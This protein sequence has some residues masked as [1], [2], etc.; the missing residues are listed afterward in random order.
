MSELEDAPAPSCRDATSP[1]NEAAREQ[2]NSAAPS[3][4]GQ[5]STMGHDTTPPNTSVALTKED[6]L[7]A[8]LAFLSAADANTLN[9][10]AIG[11]AAITYFVLGRLGILLMGA[12][13]GAVLVITWEKNHPETSRSL[14]GEKGADILERFLR[15]HKDATTSASGALRLPED[16]QVEGGKFSGFENFQPETG[17]ALDDVVDAVLRDYVKWWYTP[18]VPTDKSFP[19]SCRKTLTSF[20]VSVSKHLSRKRPADSFLD[21]LAN[22]SYLVVVFFSE[23]ACAFAEV[24]PESDMTVVDVIYNYLASNPECNL[25]NLVSRKQQESKFCMISED[26]LQFLDRPTY[27]CGLVRVFLREILAGVILETTLQKCSKP[28][29]INGWIVHLLE[30]GETDFNQALDA[31]MQT[32]PDF[33]PLGGDVGNMAIPK[34]TRKPFEQ[35]GLHP[36]RDSENLS[37]ADQD[38]EEAVRKLNEMIREQKVE[39]IQETERPTEASSSPPSRTGQQAKDSSKMQ[40]NR[41]R[42]QRTSEPSKRLL[43][44]DTLPQSR[45][46]KDVICF[47]ASP[48]GAPRP[49]AQASPNRNPGDGPFASFDQFVPQNQ[50]ANF[51]D[52]KAQKP[53]PTT[54]HDAKVT[55]YDYDSSG[56]GRIRTKPTWDYL[57]Q[58]EP[59]LSIHT[60][61]MIS[62]KFSDFESLHEVLR[63]I[64]V[65]SGVSTFV[66]QHETLPSWKVHSRESLRRELE[67]YVCDACSHQALA[68][69]EGMRRFFEKS[70]QGPA[71]EDEKSAF[72]IEN[73]G[74]NVIGALTSA[75]KG[76]LEGGKAVV[77]GVTGVLGNIGMGQKKAAPYINAWPGP[78]PS[79]APQ[80]NSIA[81]SVAGSALT[82][83]N[84]DSQRSSIVSLQS[85][86]TPAADWRPNSSSQL[87][88]ETHNACLKPATM[89]DSA[90]K[91]LSPKSSRAHSRA[92]SLGPPRTPSTISLDGIAMNLPPRPGDIADDYSPST[93]E[94]RTRMNSIMSKQESVNSI[95]TP[96]SSP[97]TSL[98]KGQNKNGNTKELANGSTESSKRSWQPEFAPLSEPETRVAIE[99]VFAMI[100]ELYSLS[101]AWTFRK[102]LLAAAKSFL[103][104]PGNPS[105]VS[106]QSMIQD[107][108]LTPLSSDSGIASHLRT[109]RKKCLP[110]EE[111]RTDAPEPMT[112]E[113]NEK[114]RA[115]ARR[116]LID[117]GMPTVLTGVMGA[118][119]TAEAMGRVFDA[120]QIEEVARGLI[121]GI[122]L[123]IV[124]IVTH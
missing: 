58:I 30:A 106:I 118:A 109:V 61:W 47:P 41:Q 80:R 27:D 85:T 101:S 81:S 23:I 98:S 26:L 83:D 75:P 111:D 92:P 121:F 38:T 50:F 104:R 105:L 33:S 69:S 18:I 122:M 13:G 77:G 5:P 70:D 8:V 16:Y 35:D 84:I 114:L 96:Q 6:V 88:G 57:V 66:D 9:A 123:Q 108:L 99:L 74:K 36:R 78:I 107:T 68:E 40:E 54:L 60:G 95:S 117:S 28:E 20:I 79:A 97:S 100:T 52:G 14:R 89:D 15:L 93:S 44:L 25:A 55:I 62:R 43:P 87:E 34:P 2:P 4:H 17:K 112:L 90:A 64:A 32:G 21:L 51:D 65:V 48:P 31:G 67:R 115:K 39:G 110:T 72:G 10:A 103:L 45:S 12:F 22:S 86:L 71:K 42:Q 24:P 120:L 19:L 91:S 46:K 73:I 102:T 11:L 119:A 116:L 29:W 7:D 76:A 124:R 59:A 53:A 49:L 3:K 94:V 1:E 63:R 56:K 37:R 113:E 82:R